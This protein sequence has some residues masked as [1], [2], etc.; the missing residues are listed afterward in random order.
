VRNGSIIE[1]DPSASARHAMGHAMGVRPRLRGMR[2]AA[3]ALMANHNGRTEQDDA[4]TY[5]EQQYR[6]FNANSDT[7]EHGYQDPR[8]QP[9]HTLGRDDPRA[10]PEPN[11]PMN[12]R[13]QSGA[14][15]GGRGAGAYRGPASRGGSD[16]Q[17]GDF[18]RGGRYA[19][20]SDDRMSSTQAPQQRWSAERTRGPHAGKGPQG[21][22]R[23]DERILELVHEVLTDHEHVDASNITVGVKDGEVTLTGH[24]DRR[25]AKLQAEDLASTVSGVKDVHNRLRVGSPSSAENPVTPAHRS[26]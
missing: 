8:D 15:A 3:V 10:A 20:G 24:V 18:D 17:W 7:L 11:P 4:R 6:N 9:D 21:Y 14:Q 16:G 2:H 19:R 12:E 22:V 23:S 25:S 13:G 1:L 5:A 26:S